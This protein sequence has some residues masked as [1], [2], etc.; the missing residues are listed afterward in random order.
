MS[1]TTLLQISC[2][3]CILFLLLFAQRCQTLYLIEIFDIKFMD[4]KVC[5]APS[6]LLKQTRPGKHLESLEF[7][8][9]SQNERLCLVKVL[10]DYIQ[11]TKN[12]RSSSRLLISTIKPF[13]AVSRSM[14]YRWVKLVMSKAGID[15]TFKPHSTRSAAASMA[16]LQGIPLGT[17]MYEDSRLV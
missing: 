6:H 3:L 5:I 11:R 8:R 16:S 17:I 14:V 15:M 4:D 13:G 1:C 10:S 7:K 2:K 9:Y 12:I